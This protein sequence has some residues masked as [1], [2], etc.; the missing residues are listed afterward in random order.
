MTDLKVEVD[1]GEV[2]FDAKRLDRIEEHFRNYVLDGRLA[3]WLVTVGRDGKLVYVA[4]HGKRDMEAGLPVQS[5]TIWR[6]YSMTKPITSLA[7]M[8]LWEE[9]RF[10]LNDPVDAYIPSFR[11]GHVYTGGSA[12]HFETTPVHQPIRIWN[13]LSHT[14]G[15][16][17]GGQ[18]DHPVDHG[19][20]RAQKAATD[21]G[22][23]DLEAMVDVWASQPLL[24]E[25]GT[26]WF[27]SR[28]TD[29]VGR[30]V[31]V[32]SGQPLDTFFAERILEPLG[33]T[34][35]AFSVPDDKTDRLASLY[36]PD[37]DSRKAVP[38]PDVRST[39]ISDFPSGGGG[40]FGTAGDYH[41]FCRLLLGGGEVDGV[42]L[43]SPKTIRMMASN[44]LPGGVDIESMA[45]EGVSETSRAGMGFGL[46][47]SIVL[48]PARTKVSGSRGEFGWG[49]AAST[50]FW[51]DPRERI[52]A[53]FFTQ[54]RPSNTWPIRPRLHQLIYQALVEPGR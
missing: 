37:P 24:F 26:H 25:P 20:Q 52:T 22:K 50:V 15:L 51:V 27:Y 9:G 32:V 34:D 30:L 4:S 45:L 13:L 44:H 23:T 7:A 31:E 48:N 28:A 16:S 21:A 43:V 18:T 17:Y 54:L 42:R 38:A 29:V 33:M 10:D 49:G 36:V 5:D 3:G 47:F 6:I 53:G 2:G 46:G 12:D 1:P 11:N 14:S 19:Y 35:T 41:R 8:M 40:L 39:R